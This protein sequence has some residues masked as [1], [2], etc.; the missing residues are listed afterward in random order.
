MSNKPKN[1]IGSFFDEI[2]RKLP[3][4]NQLSGIFDQLKPA[5]KRVKAAPVSQEPQPKPK[6]VEGKLN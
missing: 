5:P 1:Q 4:S 2:D 6:Q 3:G